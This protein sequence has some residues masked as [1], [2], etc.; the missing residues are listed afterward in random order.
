MAPPTTFDEISTKGTNPYKILNI[1][2]LFFPSS[3]TS[4]IIESEIGEF[5][6]PSPY[7]ALP[8]INH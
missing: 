8:K 5:P 4:L 6:S 2:A 3:I 1:L 7:N